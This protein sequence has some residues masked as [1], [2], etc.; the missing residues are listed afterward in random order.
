MRPPAWLFAIP[1][2]SGCS[3]NIHLGGIYFPPWMG[4]V[5]VA[6]TLSIPAVRWVESRWFAGNPSFFVWLWLPATVLISVILWFAV[7]KR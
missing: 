5:L 2:I 3:G 1:L 6:A 7:V 4:C